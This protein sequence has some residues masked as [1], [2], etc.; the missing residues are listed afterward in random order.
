[1]HAATPET[2]DISVKRNAVRIALI[3]AVFGSLPR[4]V[5]GVVGRSY[6]L[7]TRGLSG[8]HGGINSCCLER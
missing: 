7:A 4:D 5:L 8:S 1:M 2:G 3:R 6:R